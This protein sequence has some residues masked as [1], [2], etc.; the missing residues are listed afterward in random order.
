MPLINQT[1]YS[2]SNKSATISLTAG[3]KYDIK[4]DLTEAYGGASMKLYWTRPGGTSV[5]VPQAQ[6]FSAATSTP[7]PT[8][9][10]SN[11]SFDA[12]AEVF[13]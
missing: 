10:V 13:G 12:E 5:I 1:S 3:Q 6:L 4:I 11:P 2:G 7:T 9:L 8:N